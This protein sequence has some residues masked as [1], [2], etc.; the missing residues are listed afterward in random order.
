MQEMFL[1][2]LRLEKNQRKSKNTKLLNQLQLPRNQLLQ[3][4]SLI[5][6][7]TRKKLKLRQKREKYCLSLKTPIKKNK[8]ILEF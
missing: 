8:E 5:K 4:V 1:I 6:R 3:W 7:H 2:R